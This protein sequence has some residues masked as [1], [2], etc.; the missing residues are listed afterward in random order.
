[1]AELGGGRCIRRPFPAM[2]ADGFTFYPGCNSCNRHHQVLF[3]WVVILNALQKTNISHL[4]KRKII[5]KS[6][7]WWDM[8]VPKR[9]VFVFPPWGNDPIWRAYF[10]KGLV[11]PPTIYIYIQNC[12]K[13]FCMAQRWKMILSW[14]IRRF[15]VSSLFLHGAMS[16]L[17]PL[18][19]L[20]HKGVQFFGFQDG[21][22]CSFKRDGF[23]KHLLG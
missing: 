11:Q 7:F 3:C 23:L 6:E 18:Q 16:M 15:S 13:S 4:G 5:F 10:S 21:N 17:G 9:V 2:S 22:K 14:K 20:T 12:L 19:V 8:L 1:M